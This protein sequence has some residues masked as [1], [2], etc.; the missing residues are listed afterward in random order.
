MYKWFTH[1]ALQQTQHN[2][3]ARWWKADD[4]EV[5]P[6]RRIDEHNILIQIVFFPFLFIYWKL[7]KEAFLC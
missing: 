2:C 4:D 7:P 1:N 5:F 3:Q 6:V